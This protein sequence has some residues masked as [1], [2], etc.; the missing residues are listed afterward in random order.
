[1]SEE[2]KKRLLFM[3]MYRKYNKYFP[4]DLWAYLIMILIIIIAALFIL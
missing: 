4:A 3:D 2:K 1:M